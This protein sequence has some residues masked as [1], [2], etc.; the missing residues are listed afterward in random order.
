[1]VVLAVSNGSLLAR[2]ELAAHLPA[3]IGVA[4][5]SGGIMPVATAFLS[6]IRGQV[7][8]TQEMSIVALAA[9]AGAAASGFAGP[10][11]GRRCSR[12]RSSPSG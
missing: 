12:P 9:V 1:M 7:T 4:L 5:M 3:L 11:G 2:G 8:A 10:T 6:T